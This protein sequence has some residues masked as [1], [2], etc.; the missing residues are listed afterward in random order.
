MSKYRPADAQGELQGAIAAVV[1]AAAALTPL[2]MTPVFSA[3]SAEEGAVYFPGAPYLLAA[4]FACSGLL[5]S[6]QAF[7]QDAVGSAEGIAKP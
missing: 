4:L 7:R 3:F 6:I 5:L 1:S 2:L